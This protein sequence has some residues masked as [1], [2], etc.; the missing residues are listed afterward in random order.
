MS[1]NLHIA[2]PESSAAQESTQ[3][4]APENGAVSDSGRTQR[5]E[6]RPVRRVGTL[7]MGVALIVSGVVALLCMF[8]PSF[9]LLFVLKF[10][11]LIFVFLGL[12]V[13]YASI[14]RRGERIKY[15][16][17]SCFVCFLLICGAI[18]LATIPF[19]WKY[20]GPPAMQARDQ[21]NRNV[22]DL[23]YN[24]VS[25]RSHISNMYVNCEL[26]YYYEYTP[27]MDY[28]S[29]ASQMST[30]LHFSLN[31]PYEN[32]EAFAAD[33]AAI[34]AD[35]RP[36][37]LNTHNITFNYS[38]NDVSYSLDVNGR[39][40]PEQSAAALAQM[41]EVRDYSNEDYAEDTDGFDAMEN[42]EDVS[43][44][45]LEELP[46]KPEEIPSNLS[47]INRPADAM[48]FFE[49]YDGATNEGACTVSADMSLSESNIPY[50]LVRV[51]GSL[52]QA[53][54]SVTPS[55]GSF[56]NIVYINSNGDETNLYEQQ[57][58]FDRDSFTVGASL[59]A[60]YGRIEFRGDTKI[61]LELR[62]NPAQDG[63]VQI[64]HQ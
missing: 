41:V 1:D 21:L 31:G 29:L 48:A 58:N 54:F 35:I 52:A 3:S 2:G 62:I 36:L 17:L 44:E 57:N 8:L 53:S 28:E 4:T 9:N 45:S 10:S 24:A 14:F 51:D 33:A 11:P 7:T 38:D 55:D 5:K 30:Y 59:P 19:V 64:V 6:D 25:D 42:L 32:Q 15:D 37:D 56:L 49:Y 16:L 39:F 50:L 13:L 40:Q 34:L 12:E 63:S 27:D 47:T 46:D 26:P 22:E 61:H 60:G 43:A 23:L 20:A 18:G